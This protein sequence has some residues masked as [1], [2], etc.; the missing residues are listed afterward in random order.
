MNPNIIAEFMKFAQSFRGNPQET[1]QQLLN[2]G[3]ISQDQ[4][5]QAVQTAQQ[6]Q[7]MLPPS[8]HRR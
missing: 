1:V 5:N 8:V 2:S 4:Y 3:Q 6:L 7:Q